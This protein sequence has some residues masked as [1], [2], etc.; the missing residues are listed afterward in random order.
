[1]RAAARETG[2]APA[3]LAAYA[4]TVLPVAHKEL[5][6]WRR[7]AEAIPDSDRRRRALSTLEEKRGNVEAVT[8]FA[9]LA[10]RRRR[11]AVLRAIVPLQLAIDYCDTLEEAGEAEGRP[12][13]YLTALDRCAEGQRQTHSAVGGDHAELQRWAEGLDETGAYRWWELAAG[14]SS[15]VAAHALIAA[16]ADPAASA[17]TAAS[18]DAAYNPS[19]GALT[20]FFDDL[21]DR[22]ADREAGEHSYLDYYEGSEEAA[23]RLAWIAEEAGSRIEAL[24]HAH[25]HRAIL[26]GVGSFYLSAPETKNTYAA[27]PRTTACRPR[28]RHARAR[29]FY[30][31]AQAL[32][33][34]RGLHPAVV[35][36]VRQD[37]VVGAIDGASELQRHP[38][39]PVLVAGL[40]LLRDFFEEFDLG[41]DVAEPL[42]Q[43]SAVS[44]GFGDGGQLGSSFLQRS[45][46][47]RELARGQLQLPGLD[48]LFHALQDPFVGLPVL[49]TDRFHLRLVCVPFFRQIGERQRGH[50]QQEQ[51]AERTRRRDLP[52]PSHLLP[53]VV[54]RLSTR[55]N[56]SREASIL[57]CAWL[58]GS[59]RPGNR[60]EQAGNSPGAASQREPCPRW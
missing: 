30:D 29:R 35:E 28:T 1:V 58:Q 27:N 26:A 5:Q 60:P 44:G 2:A 25:R 45:G 16:A 41:L 24:P 42:R 52:R 6:Q 20:V 3:A 18:T 56:P 11:R 36:F 31:P 57:C 34:L 15:S 23:E 10:P 47:L 19:I 22:E 51:D 32:E 49:L 17:C 12:D 4:V 48:V 37:S 50:R 40:Q 53:P 38:L 46:T 33:E 13:S 7:Q 9:I 55:S 59:L 8:V 14:A 43:P 39:C 21:V 54:D